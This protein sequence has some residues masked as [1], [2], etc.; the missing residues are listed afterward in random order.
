LGRKE[1]EKVSKGKDDEGDKIWADFCHQFD[2]AVFKCADTGLGA[3]L[4][5]SM[6]NHT[7]VVDVY[8]QGGTMKKFDDMILNAV[9]KE[10]GIDIVDK[11]G[12]K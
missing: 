2:K 6:G 11:E 3:R 5:I 10:T 12:V 7:V 4:V 9:K 8:K 1:G